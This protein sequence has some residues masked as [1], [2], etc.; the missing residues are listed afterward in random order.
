MTRWGI[1]IVA[2][3]KVP[4]EWRVGGR[5]GRWAIVALLLLRNYEGGRE[6]GL[7]IKGE[8]C[9]G[10]PG[11]KNKGWSR[12]YRGRKVDWTRLTICQDPARWNDHPMT[13]NTDILLGCALNYANCRPIRHCLVPGITRGLLLGLAASRRER[14]MMRLYFGLDWGISGKRIFDYWVLAIYIL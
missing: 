11:E 10:A 14:I 1:S 6:T 12:L 3:P 7:T 9:R 5:K 13:I 8:R 4:Y 2:P